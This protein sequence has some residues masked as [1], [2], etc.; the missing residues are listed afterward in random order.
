MLV[1][2]TTENPAYPLGKLVSAKHSVGL[3]HLALAMHPFG[4]DR[5]E[6]RALLGQKA[7]HDPHPSPALLD[8]SVVFPEPSSHL[9]AYVPG[10]V[11]P[12]E[13][14]HL[15][16]D[17]FEPLATPLKESGR[18]RTHGSI[19]HEAQPRLVEL[20][21][22]EPVTQEMA[23]GSGSSLATYC[24][25]RRKGCFP[26]SA[27]LLK[28]GKASR[29][30]QHSSQKPTAH[31]GSASATLI[32]RSRRLFSFV[33]GIGGGDPPLGSLPAHSSE[34]ARQSSQDGLPRDSPLDEPLLEAH[35]C[36]HL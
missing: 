1:M 28:V 13:N 35:L 20:R 24:W 21:H 29:L 33:E 7:A 16:A 31:S 11:V 19:I 36:C 23:F 25:T 10:S 8:L 30:H 14:Q 3:Y 26:S 18:Y 27:Q 6:P 17:G 4:L 22:I 5:V 9:A 15:L 2:R 32:S 34:K 12:D